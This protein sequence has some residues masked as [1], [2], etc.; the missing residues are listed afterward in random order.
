MNRHR[1]CN[2][3]E[4]RTRRLRT[5]HAIT[6]SAAA[7]LS[8]RPNASWQCWPS[9]HRTRKVP[10]HKVLDAINGVKVNGASVCGFRPRAEQCMR[11]GQS[12]SERDARAQP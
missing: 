5:R 2:V 10:M 11:H 3:T 4:A 1:L 7:A 12:W 6:C 8:Q 9:W